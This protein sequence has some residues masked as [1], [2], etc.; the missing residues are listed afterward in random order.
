LIFDQ[1]GLHVAIVGSDGRIVLREVTIA[2]D[3]GNEVELGSG[4]TADDR[5]VINPP[6]GIAS[7]EKVR[8]AGQPGEPETAEAK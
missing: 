1:S 3:L 5:V 6:D 7:G 2:R 4:I 8:I